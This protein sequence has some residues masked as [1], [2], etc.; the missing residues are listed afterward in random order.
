VRSALAATIL[1]ILTTLS[2][3]AT[4]KEIEL[5]LRVKELEAFLVGAQEDNSLLMAAVIERENYIRALEGGMAIQAGQIAKLR[6]SNCD[7]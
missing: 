5:T 1:A 2:G 7:L 6:K 4:S 3:C